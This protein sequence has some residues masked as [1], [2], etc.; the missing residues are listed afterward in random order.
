MSS[1]I[2]EPTS[3]QSYPTRR[4]MRRQMRRQQKIFSAV[5]KRFQQVKE[6]EDGYAFC[7]PRSKAWATKLEKFTVVWTKYRP[8]FTTELDFEP[9]QGPI[10]LS[11]RG[12]EGTKEFIESRLRSNLRKPL[13]LMEKAVK[14]GFRVLTSPIR[15]MPDFLI[16]G[17][18]KCG[19]TS[20]YSYLIQH[21]CVAPAFKKEV[22]FFDDK[23]RRGFTWYRSQFPTCFEKYYARQIGRKDFVTGE[24]TPC[25]LFH[26]HVPKRIFERIPKVKLI[27]LLR[28]PVNRAY[29]YYNMKVRQGYE[30]LSF[31]EAIERE[32]QRLCGELEKMLEDENYFS[33]NRQH[34]SYLSRGIYV[35]Q[36]KTW[37]NFFSE[38]QFLI[39][40]TE[41]FYRDPSKVFKQVLEF[42][43]L[44][45]WELKEYKK[46]NYVPYPKMDATTRKCLIEYFEPHN[47]RLYEFLG[48]N[49]GWG[50]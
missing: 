22:Y 30:T 16:I 8:F 48:V 32:Q 11:I 46:L 45:S 7:Y 31:Q 41:D 13:S 2:E 1:R 26:P 21:P 6:L 28:N 15:V 29:S 34:Y 36:L 18:A 50:R 43:S 33:F 24:A 14:Q 47:Q 9:N 5:F 25:Y 3:E 42:L 35:D 37:V 27:V 49:F 19:T 38:E 39:L 23:F 10:W 12:P 4:Q 17:A 44:P 20:L 40:K